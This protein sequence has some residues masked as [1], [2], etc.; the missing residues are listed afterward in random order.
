MNPYEPPIQAELV[1]KP[2]GGRLAKVMEATWRTFIVLLI[3]IFLLAAASYLPLVA[4]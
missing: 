1:D 4:R 3:L 2:S